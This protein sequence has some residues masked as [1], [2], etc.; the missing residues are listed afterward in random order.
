MQLPKIKS[1]FRVIHKFILSFLIVLT[2]PFILLSFLLYDSQVLVLKDSINSGYNNAISQVKT[3]L[4][5]IMNDFNTTALNI[6]SKY[7]ITKLVEN[8]NEYEQQAVIAYCTN[9][10]TPIPSVFLYSKSDYSTIVTYDEKM[11]MSDFEKLMSNAFN[12]TMTNFFTRINQVN[13]HEVFPTNRVSDTELTSGMFFTYP[14]PYSDIKTDGSVIF[15]YNSMQ[16]NDIFEDYMGSINGTVLIFD[17]YLNIVYLNNIGDSDTIGNEA[18]YDEIKKFRGSGV[19]ELDEALLA[20]SISETTGMSYCVLLDYDDAYFAIEEET[21]NFYL[22]I[23][24]ISFVGIMLAVVFAYYNYSPIRKLVQKKGGTNEIDELR[25]IVSSHDLLQKEVAKNMPIVYNR[26]LEQILLGQ[27]S[28]ENLD[29]FIQR[30]QID[31][32]YDK[33]NVIIIATSGNTLQM[34]ANIKMPAVN[35]Y[36]LELITEKNLTAIIVNFNSKIDIVHIAENISNY[37]CEKFRI[38]IGTDC[39]T[40]YKCSQSFIKAKIAVDTTQDDS[41]I[42]KYQDKNYVTS[43]YPEI[44]YSLLNQSIRYSNTKT[45]LEAVDIIISFI[46][47]KCS[48]FIIM[49]HMLSEVTGNLLHFA[50]KN[51]IPLDVNDIISKQYHIDDITEFKSHLQMLVTMLCAQN[52]KQKELNYSAL[53]KNI[54]I[55]I[56]QNFTRNEISLQYV[57]DEFNISTS[58]LAKIVFEETEMTFNNYITILRISRTKELLLTTDSKIKDIVTAVGYVDTASFI[59]KFK[60]AEDMTP[61][62]Y[63]DKHKYT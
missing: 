24:S 9:S 45:A 29:Y 47:D 28:E 23:G 49:R 8:G 63:R 4:D 16:I 41:C 57:A 20:K 35:I 42:V 50:S 48:S 7:D 40:P 25:S 14:L 5:Y 51:S 36:P 2:I 21:Q 37:L 31:F 22:L 39:G 19:F 62:Q 53:K 38:G 27:N 61:G 17:E 15:H 26:C 46:K 52:D 56:S 6:G 55:Y 1:N 60:A 30:A 44:D 59:R 13:I 54:I 18:L 10:V 32:V 12:M 34:L 11:S 3:R 43:D 33:F 58:Y